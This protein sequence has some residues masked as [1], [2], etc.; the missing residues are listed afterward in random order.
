MNVNGLVQVATVDQCPPGTVMTTTVNNVDIALCNYEGR[1][2]AVNNR[3][4]H[5]GGQLGDGHL[6]GSDL[7]CPLHGWDFDVRTGIS[8]YNTLDRVDT[9]PVT[10]QDG[11][12]YLSEHDVPSEPKEYDDYLAKWRRPFDDREETMSYVH[13]LA[14]GKGKKLEAMRTDQR[15]PGFDSLLFLPGQVASLP[16]LDDEPV[17]LTCVVGPRARKPIRLRIPVYVSHMSYGSLSPESKTAMATGARR[18]GT[19]ICS[20]EGGMHPMERAAAGDYIF[21]MA[22]G[23]FGFNEENVRKATGIDFKFGQSAK[24][25]LGGILPA[26]KVTAEI[27]AVRGVPAGVEVHSPSRF[28]DLHSLDDLK[29]R[30]EELR[31]KVDGPIG[32][33]MAASHIERDLEAAMTCGF[34]FVTIDGRGGG[35]GA[36]PI[37]VK[38]NICVPL[39]YAIPRARRWLDEHGYD[40]VTLV[41][42]GGLR[43]PADFAK[44]LA[45]G[46][47]CVAIATAAMMAI[48]CQQYRACHNNTC[49]VGIATQRSELRNRFDIQISAQR[50]V[51][52]LQATETELLDFCRMMGHRHVRELNK[53]DLVT[54][55]MA[56]AQYGRIPHA[57][58]YRG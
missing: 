19:A 52:F 45:L 26:H 35:T 16:L 4:P 40:D 20:G 56:L 9:Y 50:L 15:L 32:A 29:A 39:V 53:N 18:F 1:Y 2:Y 44:A 43:T 47:N 22:S 48:G 30:I 46:A 27:A 58:E 10:V 11:K 25:G 57:A 36:A 31:T 41:A 7:I 13:Y 55:D 3:C 37:H 24:A 28:P 38:D 49:P 17:D 6:Q 33:K 34:D 21:E 14:R 54:L 42:T 5:R 51:N 12:I 23:Y 8:R